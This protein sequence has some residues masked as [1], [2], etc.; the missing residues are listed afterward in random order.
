MGKKNSILNYA[1]IQLGIPFP[2]KQRHTQ[3]IKKIPSR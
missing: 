1:S 2:N 3:N